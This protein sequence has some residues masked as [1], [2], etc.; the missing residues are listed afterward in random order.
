MKTKKNETLKTVLIISVGFAILFFL[1]SLK[2]LLIVSIL[3]GLLGII[4]ENVS[5]LISFLWM[6]LSKILS[7]IISNTLLTLV[8][9]LILFPLALLSKLIGK[10]DSLNLKN[11]P[12]SLGKTYGK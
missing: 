5:G 2:W 1:T 12:E 8:F 4:S 6:Q 9:Y 7:F 3:V 11:K 10:G